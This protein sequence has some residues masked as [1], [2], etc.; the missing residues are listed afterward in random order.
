MVVV[1][2]RER[3][4]RVGSDDGMVG[5]ILGVGVGL[6]IGASEGG[7]ATYFYAC[8]PV[9]SSHL[10]G[11]KVQGAVCVVHMLV[12]AECMRLHGACC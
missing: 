11:D 6:I 4:L 1:A 8:S 12:A 7:D 10:P 9:K 5:L 3:V 2:A